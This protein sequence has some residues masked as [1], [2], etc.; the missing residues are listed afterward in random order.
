MR[1]RIVI[2][3]FPSGDENLIYSAVRT[4]IPNIPGKV[5]IYNNGNISYGFKYAMLERCDNIEFIND[6]TPL[7]DDEEY[8][9]L[10]RPGQYL[11]Y[12]RL[13]EGHS[14]IFTKDDIER[15]TLNVLIK[16]NLRGENKGPIISLNTPNMML[17]YHAYQ[18]NWDVYTFFTKINQ[19]V[20]SNFPIFAK[21][22]K[23]D[24]LNDLPNLIVTLINEPPMIRRLYLPS[25]TTLDILL[26][27]VGYEVSYDQDCTAEVL[28]SKN[29]NNIQDYRAII[30]RGAGNSKLTPSTHKY[31][32]SAGWSMILDKSFRQRRI[33]LPGYFNEVDMLKFRIKELYNDVD[34]FIIGQMDTPYSSNNLIEQG[35][36][37]VDDPDNKVKL[38]TL[39]YPDEIKALNDPW[40]KDRYYRQYSIYH[41]L[42]EDY[43]ILFVLDL[44]EIPDVNTIRKETELYINDVR[45]LEMMMHYYNFKWVKPN[46]WYHGYIGNVN[47]IRKYGADNIRVNSPIRYPVVKK[48]GWHISYFLTPLLIKKKIESFAHQ[49]W[50]KYPYT[51]VI[52]IAN[53]IEH[54]L[55]L[56]GRSYDNMIPADSK[57]VPK[58]YKLLN[59]SYWP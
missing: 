20:I 22:I 27:M 55:D 11:H 8:L 44:D 4:W 3:R 35:Y 31:S 46:H 37:N 56:Y 16:T 39:K 28:I 13:N 5:Y 15:V 23:L 57:Y 42:I 59:E 21:S 1:Y 34:L 18:T 17:N 25:K 49:E 32:F 48:G 30:S 26:N 12:D 2:L 41:P 58:E 45:R 54:G 47:E 36:P 19:T 6:I 53:C 10:L 43:D 24:D 50:N 51:D 40:I 14:Q 7:I 9:V 33:D 52:Y 38:L 29:Y